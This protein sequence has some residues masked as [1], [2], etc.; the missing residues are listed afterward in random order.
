MND[1][2]LMQRTVL[3]LSISCGK[4]YGRSWGLKVASILRF[5]VYVYQYTRRD[6]PENLNLHSGAAEPQDLHGKL[7]QTF[8][9]MFLPQY[10]ESS[11]LRRA[12]LIILPG[13]SATITNGRSLTFRMTSLVLIVGALY[14]KL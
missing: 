8:S 7:L 9:R 4:I 13:T 5:E 10:S 12:L 14:H 3:P 1:S 2:C 6:N 11:S